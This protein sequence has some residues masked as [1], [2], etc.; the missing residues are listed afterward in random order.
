M[1]WSHSWVDEQGG[2]PSDR[3]GFLAAGV[4]AV[5]R[6]GPEPVPEDPA[7]VGGQFGRRL[8]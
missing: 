7:D 4:S 8:T 3:A 5:E 1:V 6:D 2:S